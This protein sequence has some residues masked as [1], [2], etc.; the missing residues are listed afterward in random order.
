M[1]GLLN[2]LKNIKEELY[3]KL[4]REPSVIEIAKAMGVKKEK[5]AELE[6]FFNRRIVSL[7][8]P[9]GDADESQRLIDTIV[10]E[11]SDPE[12]LTFS[13][14]KIGIA[15]EVMDEKLTDRERGIIKARNGIGA[16]EKTLRELGNE[17]G[18]TRER[19]RQIENEGYDKLRRDPRL[20]KL[21]DEREA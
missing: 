21:A 10:S 20:R 1:Q 7:D 6:V 12:A 18:I 11:N 13:N 9:L 3:I 2:K 17:N 14:Q 15:N 19:I 8:M 16:T 4:G 5:A